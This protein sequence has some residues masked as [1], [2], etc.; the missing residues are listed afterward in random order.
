MLT[1][2]L[3]FFVSRP[4]SY[5]SSSRAQAQLGFLHYVVR[6]LWSNIARHFPSFQYRVDHVIAREEEIDFEQVRLLLILGGYEPSP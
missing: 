3:R 5:F 2:T 6:P 4:G 1:L